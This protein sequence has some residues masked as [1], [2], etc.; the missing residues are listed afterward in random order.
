MLQDS[1]KLLEKDVPVCALM[2]PLVCLFHNLF[3][4]E[5]YN[6]NSLFRNTFFSG[7]L[8]SYLSNMGMQFEPFL[9]NYNT[10]KNIIIFYIEF[11]S[12]ATLTVLHF[13]YF[14]SVEML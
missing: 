14:K 12:S 3:Y 6:R 2:G 10:V 8:D 11:Y 9:I 7:S 1:H 4:E 13:L 5:L